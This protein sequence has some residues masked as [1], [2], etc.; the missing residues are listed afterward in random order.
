MSLYRFNKGDTLLN[1]L[2]ARPSYNFFIY[3]ND[4]YLNE[5]EPMSGAYSSSVTNVPPGYVN[6]YELNVNRASGNLIYPL[7]IL[8][9]IRHLLYP[10]CRQLLK[11]SR[12]RA[13]SQGLIHF[14]RRSV[15]FILKVA[16]PL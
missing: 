12:L 5:H 13:P 11:F 15:C 7:F 1:T 9:M 3:Q 2:V 16:T 8:G 6:L 10:L 14:L 4:L